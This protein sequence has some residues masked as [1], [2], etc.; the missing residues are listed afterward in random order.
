MI[1][2]LF[3]TNTFHIYDVIDNEVIV[4]TTT[5]KDIASNAFNKKFNSYI[6]G[7]DIHIC[8]APGMKQGNKLYVYNTSFN[9]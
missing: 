6:V 3:N 8:I 4:T 1:Q 2:D 9:I 5:N 7:N